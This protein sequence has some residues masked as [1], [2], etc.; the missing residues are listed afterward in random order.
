MTVS[1]TRYGR[2]GTA[3]RAWL[4]S[5]IDLTTLV[6]HVDT[7]AERIFISSGHITGT[8]KPY[9]GLLPDHIGNAIEEVDA[10]ILETNVLC[11]AYSNSAQARENSLEII[12]AVE[13]LAAQNATTMEDA[14]FSS[15]NIQ[16]VGIR[17]LGLTV[18]GESVGDVHSGVYLSSCVLRIRWRDTL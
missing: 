9:L 8:P 10:G 4:V 13:A 1:K 17:S 3:L 6:G 7:T 16:T 15:S 14:S 18:S 5:D 11:E 2:F 12:A